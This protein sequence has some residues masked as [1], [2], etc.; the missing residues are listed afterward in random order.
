MN[1]NWVVE[2][3]E[4]AL[5]NVLLTTVQIASLLISN[6]IKSKLEN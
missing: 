5:L 6:W 2:E 3:V 1:N 4:K